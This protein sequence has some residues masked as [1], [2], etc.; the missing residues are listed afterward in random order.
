M[1]ATQSLKIF[2]VLQ[3]HFKNI[4]D[5]KVVVEEIEQIIEDRFEDKKEQ[6]SYKSEV[7]LLRRDLDSMKIELSSKIE[8]SSLRVESSL[9]LEINKL[10]V[11]IIATIFGSVALFTTAAKVFFDK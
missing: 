1:T 4:A 11:W 2:E 7:Q 6:F 8:N 10:I 5:A 3:P 9:Q